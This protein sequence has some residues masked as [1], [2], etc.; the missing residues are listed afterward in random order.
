M[1]ATIK[2]IGKVQ[3]IKIIIILPSLGGGG[4]ER[5]HVNLAN[6]WVAKG[7]DVE[8]ILL[9]VDGKLIS[10]LDT[11]IKITFI[12]VNRIRNIILPLVTKLRK[13]L[14][15]VLLVAMWPLTSAVVFS[16]V[17]SGRKGRLF[18]SDHENLSQSYIEQHRIGRNYLRNLIRFTYPLANGIIAVS[19]GVMQ[20][21]QLLGKLKKEKIRVIY[22]PAAIG[23]KTLRETPE[24]QAKL[25]GTGFNRHILSVGRLSPQKDHE[26][27]IKAF[28]MLPK[29]INAKLIILGEG[30]LRSDLLALISKLE[31][32]EC[33]ELPGFTADPYPWF[34]SADLFVLSSRW[35]GFGNVIVEA[36]ECGVPVVS[37][38]CPSGPDEI[39]EDG[40]Y[41]MLVPIQDSKALSIA[42]VQS[43]KS[44]HD[45][46]RL[47]HRAQDFSIRKISE[48]YLNYFFDDIQSLDEII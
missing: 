25:W 1:C 38:S 8:F 20:D 18:I 9:R 48:Q 41:G 39:L 35:E 21:L 29:E 24:V 27:L 22:N 5:L 31:L 3:N 42:M 28:A 32:N 33:I 13:S 14:P 15:D 44:K 46:K 47:M 36:L 43:L 7:F 11:R 34:R 23:V 2:S 16:W 19:Q 17:L 37:T 10:L 4:A 30:S 26:T 6:D 45:H 40:L 12:A